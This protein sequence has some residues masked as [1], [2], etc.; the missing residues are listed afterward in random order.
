MNVESWIL[1]IDFFSVGPSNVNQ[2]TNKPS[3]EKQHSRD[4]LDSITNSTEMNVSVRSLTVV[5]VRPERDLAK[6]NISRLNLSIKTDGLCKEIKGELGSMSLL[7]LTLHGQ[8]YRER[9][10]TSGKQALNFS[11]VR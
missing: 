11:Y 8:L 2:I 4:I 3:I 7:D 5:L 6:A 9:F 10:L 1:V